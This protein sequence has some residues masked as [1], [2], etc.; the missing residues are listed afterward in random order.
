MK[1]DFVISSLSG[2]GA[3]RVITTLSKE[4]AYKGNSVNLISLEKRKQFYK[5]NKKVNLQKI[6]NN[7]IFCWF[8]DIVDL[9]RLLRQ[10]NSDLVVSFLSRTNILIILLS[11][12]NKRR[13][14]I[15]DRNNPIR[16]HSKLVRIVSNI[17][18]IRANKIIV[19]TNKIKS[20]YP[21]YLNKKILVVENAIDNKE[22]LKQIEGKQISQKNTIISIGRL[23]KQKDFKTLIKAFKK[24]SDNFTEWN[25]EIYGIGS[26][27]EELKKEIDRLNL[28]NRVLLKGRTDNP[29]LKLSES[30]IFVLSSF[31]E[32]FPNVLCEAMFTGIGC[33]SSNCISGPDELIDNGKNGFLFDVENDEQLSKILSRLIKDNKLRSEI[34]KEAKNTVE[35]LYLENIFLQWESIFKDI[36]GEL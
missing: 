16:E 10:N 27:Q 13:I 19:Q 23:E 8:K 35:R 33:V 2:G 6:N 21:K 3:E 15:C 29:I 12:F 18:Y 36:L 32:G 14:V 25:V 5:V 4:F 11:L 20:F 24:I 7:N 26:M 30:K 34:G 22:L 31:Y 9:R 1:I 17:L 28:N